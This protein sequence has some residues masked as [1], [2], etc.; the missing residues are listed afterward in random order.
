MKLWK[1]WI[2]TDWKLISFLLRGKKFNNP[3][4]FRYLVRN[5]SMGFTDFLKVI[6]LFFFNGILLALRDLTFTFDVRLQT[7]WHGLHRGLGATP[8]WLPSPE[9]G[10]YPVKLGNGVKHFNSSLKR[11]A[12]RRTAGCET[13]WNPA[14][15]RKIRRNPVKPATDLHRKPP[16]FFHWISFY[17]SVPFILWSLFQPSVHL[18]PAITWEHS[19]KS[20]KIYIHM[21]NKGRKR[22]KNDLVTST[23]PG[24]PFLESPQ[25]ISKRKEKKATRNVQRRNEWANARNGGVK[26]KKKRE[27]NGGKKGLKRGPRKQRQMEIK[28]KPEGELVRK[29]KFRLNT[30]ASESSSWRAVNNTHTEIIEQPPYNPRKPQ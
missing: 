29:S 14:N 11:M 3:L 10:W 2:P 19:A 9:T 27:I 15:P 7:A 17:F 20:K 4:G 8:A 28:W 5:V 13:R 1:D 25:R 24:L 12:P 26:K 16:P 23:D 21:T 18:H 6:S 30:A 22:E